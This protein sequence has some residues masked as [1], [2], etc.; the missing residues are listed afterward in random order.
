MILLHLRIELLVAAAF[1]HER[2]PPLI[3]QPLIAAHIPT[4][5]FP[6]KCS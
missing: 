1:L 3:E 6:R 2:S 5:A 4:A